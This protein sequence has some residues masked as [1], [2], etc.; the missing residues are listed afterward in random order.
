MDI[1]IG[2]SRPEP[3]F[4][5]D[6]IFKSIQPAVEHLTLPKVN[7]CR[8]HP[9]EIVMNRNQKIAVAIGVALVVLSGIFPPYEGD[10]PGEKFYK[11]RI[12]RLS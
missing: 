11:N 7:L 10:L 12:L 6:K 3:P 2:L 5:I 4:S 1:D 8:W 9:G